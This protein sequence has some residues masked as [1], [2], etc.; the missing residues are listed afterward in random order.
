[1]PSFLSHIGLDVLQ[2]RVV[3]VSQFCTG[4][5]ARVRWAHALVAF[6]SLQGTFGQSSTTA[7]ADGLTSAAQ[8]TTAPASI[9]T[10]TV[11]GTARTYSVPFTV[12]AAADVGP[13]ELPNIYNPQAKQAQQVCPGYT[14]SGVE[15][16]SN[17]F[18]ASLSLAGDAC[19]VY[20]T[21]VEDLKLTVEYQSN[22]RLHVSIQPT[23]LGSTNTSHYILP[24]DL[25]YAPGNDN[26]NCSQE[27][28]FKFSWSNDP[29]FS[30]HI[31]RKSTGM[32][33]AHD[34]TAVQSLMCMVL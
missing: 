20:G 6:S 7:K 16:T 29:T 33:Q 21:D 28:D 3:D 12:P 10:A 1:M 8:V 19:N 15:R 22:H 4:T 2:Q 34:Q 18:T 17:G 13:N 11:D 9:A 5:M 30:F 27:I 23:Y 24:A 25:V 26:G 32:N 14:A 31:T